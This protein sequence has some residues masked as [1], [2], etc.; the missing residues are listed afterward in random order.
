M[1]KMIGGGFPVGAIAG[2]ADIMEVMNPLAEQVLFP[3]SGTFSANPVSMTAGLIAMRLYDQSAVNRLNRLTKMAR[4][5]IAEAIEIAGFP[6][7]VTGGGSM[8]RLHMKPEPPHDYRS[9]FATPE[10]ARKLKLLLDY[11]FD[12]GVMLIGTGSGALSTAMTETEIDT[13]AQVML[14]GFRML[15]QA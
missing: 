13:L 10:Q 3:H 1:G 8:F 4:H 2:R 7:C 6:A 11:A 14:E 15:K 12:H 9:T 5:R